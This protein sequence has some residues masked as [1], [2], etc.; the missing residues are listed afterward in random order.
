MFCSSLGCNNEC[1]T[2][3]GQEVELSAATWQHELNGDA[4]HDRT[5]RLTGFLRSQLLTRAPATGCEGM[6]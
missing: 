5:F 6:T 1:Y 3:V 2:P 4:K